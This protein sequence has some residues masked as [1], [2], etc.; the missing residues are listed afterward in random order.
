[1]TECFFFQSDSAGT[2]APL[3]LSAIGGRRVDDDPLAY[4]PESHPFEDIDLPNVLPDLPGNEEERRTWIWLISSLYFGA[5]EYRSP[6]RSGVAEDLSF[7]D[8]NLDF[9]S[10]FLDLPSDLPTSLSVTGRDSGTTTPVPT[11]EQ[12]ALHVRIILSMLYFG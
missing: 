8:G 3:D 10:S 11:F 1:M 12:N 4:R 2:M 6:L 5:C 9:S 7:L